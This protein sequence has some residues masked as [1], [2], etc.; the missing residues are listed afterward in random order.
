MKIYR[1]ELAAVSLLFIDLQFSIE[2]PENNILFIFRDLF[3][4]LSN[5][6]LL[7]LMKQ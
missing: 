4:F 7:M 3:L 2:C 6:I 5:D 1:L